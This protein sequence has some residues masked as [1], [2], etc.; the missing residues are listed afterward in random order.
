MVAAV[1][2]I[3]GCLIGAR[4][5]AA[6]AFFLVGTTGYLVFFN[7]LL[8]G[9]TRHHGYLFVVWVLT[10]WL[11]W[12]G[13]QSEWPRIPRVGV[14]AEAI[15]RRLFTCSLVIP[16]VATI[17]YVVADL[18]GPFADTR[19]VAA[20]IREQGLE[21]APII[22]L[23]RL[24]AQPVGALLDRKVLFPV[25]GKTLSFIEWGRGAR[26][27]TSARATDSVATVLLARECRVVVVTAAKNDVLPSTASRGRAIYTTPRPPMTGDR[28]RVWLLSA[29]AT[30]RCPTARR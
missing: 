1:V 14:G 21:R 15:G 18:R 12:T 23:S 19:R 7:F 24:L 8:S 16:V 3:V 27:S 9:S 17:E 10:A 6:L 11:A 13:R 5:R 20:V 22:G 2:L 4:R 28:Y 30:E 29:P 25:E 26:H